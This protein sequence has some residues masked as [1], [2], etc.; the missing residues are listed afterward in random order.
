MMDDKLAIAVPVNKGGGAKP[1]MVNAWMLNVDFELEKTFNNY[2]NYAHA[3]GRSNRNKNGE[4][5]NFG[6]SGDVI[7][8]GDALYAQIENG[9]NIMY[10]NDFSLKA[11]EDALYYLFAGKTDFNKRNVVMRT[12]ERGG[13]KFQKAA[14]AQ[15]SGWVAN[16][17]VDAV[18]LGLMKKTNNA[19]APWGGAISVA[20]PQVF[21]YIAPM[22]IK[23]TLEIDQTKDNINASG[24]KLT[25]PEGGLV[26][27]YIFDILDLGT[28]VEPNIQK[29][30][31][32]GHPDEW[33]GYE[34]G[35]RNPFTGA[36]NNDHMSNDED[37]AVIH[38]MADIGIVVWD[39]TR[40]VRIMPDILEA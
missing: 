13:A 5:Q 14:L 8:T 17:D 34:A 39:P 37:A 36:W 25:H 33:R 26:S 32:K 4:Y 21:E 15:G 19:A 9:G 24:I 16:M 30:K 29:C 3:W 23:I 11:I 27:S 10:Y 40:T 18:N 31:I 38:K 20:A 35:M 28:G 6:K 22:G 1:S 7:K 12:G 2:K